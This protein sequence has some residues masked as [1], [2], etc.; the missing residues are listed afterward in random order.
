M[1]KTLLSLGLSAVLASAL[2]AKEK[3]V[4]FH[5][6]SLAVPFSEIE[7]EFEAKYPEYDVQREASGSRAA[8]RKISEI[9]RAADVM[10]SADYKVIDNLL[11]PNNAKFNAQFATN[12]MAIAFTPSSKYA[13]EINSNNWPEIFLRDGVKVGH[14]NPNMDPCGYRSILVTKLAEEHYKIP[15]FYEKL[16]GYGQSYKVGEEDK[17]KVIVRPKETDLLG[18]IEANAYDYLYIY[19]SV[20]K[21]HGLKYITLPKEVSLKDNENAKFYKTAKF[22][23]DGKKPGTFITKTGGAMVYGITVAQ[24]KKSPANKEGAVKFVNFVLSEKGQEIMK[25]NGQGVIS[26]A[27]ITGDA[28]IIGK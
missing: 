11:V 12:E 20:A 21:Q 25:K 16:F 19:K 1:K 5:A 15:G 14:S 24:N 26:P 28:S 2:V 8:A 23:I 4:V 18:L 17:N 13:D 3:I 22:D 6:G 9:G 27:K 10:A 7:K